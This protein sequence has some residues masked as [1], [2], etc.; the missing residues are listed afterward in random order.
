LSLSTYSQI[1]KKVDGEK[2]VVFTL[3]QAKQVNDTF[4]YQR[5]EIE[6]LKNIK[7]IVRV[8]TVE[9]IKIIQTEQKDQLFTIEG[10]VFMVVQ[11]IIMFPLIFIK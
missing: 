3:V 2:V 5:A 9:I 11:G 4:V 1:I 6:R 10:L 7:P 8:D